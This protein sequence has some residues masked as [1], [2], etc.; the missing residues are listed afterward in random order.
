VAACLDSAGLLNVDFTVLHP[1]GFL[2]LDA[3][4]HD[5]LLLPFVDGSALIREYQAR[6]SCSHW[7]HHL[8]LRPF[9]FF[10]KKIIN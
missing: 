3:T 5:V 9:Y 2:C 1:F 4:L 7:K 6:T 8:S 10:R